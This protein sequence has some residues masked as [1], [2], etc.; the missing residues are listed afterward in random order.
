MVL[1]RIFG[2]MREAVPGGWRKFYNEEGHNLCASQN[3][4]RVIKSSHGARMG[5][6]GNAYM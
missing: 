2:L 6:M 1:R 5:M 3:I 4:I